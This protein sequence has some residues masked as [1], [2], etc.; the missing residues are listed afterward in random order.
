[1]ILFDFA[2]DTLFFD[3]WMLAIC[4]QFRYFKDFEFEKLRY[5]EGPMPEVGNIERLALNSE[6]VDSRGLVNT[7][8]KIRKRFRNLKTFFVVFDRDEI[9]NNPTTLRSRSAIQFVEAPS[10]T[11]CESRVEGGKCRVC[12]AFEELQEYSKEVRNLQS[13]GMNSVS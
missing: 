1:M 12:R 8:L 4:S 7:I 5:P 3:D 13:V 9:L 2:R 6:F 10:T 11:S